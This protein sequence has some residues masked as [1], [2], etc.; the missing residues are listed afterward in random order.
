[1]AI[2]KCQFEYRIP[3]MNKLIDNV[4]GFNGKLFIE[5]IEKLLFNNVF[6]D[7]IMDKNYI[8]FTELFLNDCISYY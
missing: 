8:E 2:R 4:K 3:S 6:E 7:K 1:M 5:S